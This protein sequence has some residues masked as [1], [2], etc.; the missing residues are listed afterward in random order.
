MTSV[1]HAEFVPS[2]YTLVRL[3]TVSSY[4]RKIDR[5]LRRRAA[6]QVIAAR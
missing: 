4:V 2:Q 6:G 5:P 1:V 3:H